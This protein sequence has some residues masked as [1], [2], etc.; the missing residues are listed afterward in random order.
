M[1]NKKWIAILCTSVLACGMT[2]H[3]APFDAAYY[4]QQNPDVVAVVGNDAAAL[5]A[6]YNAFGAAEG[7][8]G[9]A[10]DAG[11]KNSGATGI[12]AIFDAA[13]YAEHN[14]D[15]VALV[16]NDPMALYTHF[17]TVGINEGRFGNATFNAAAYKDANPDLAAVY[18]ND[19]LAYAN[20]Y[21]TVG[22]AEGRK[23]GIS[24]GSNGSGSSAKAN[25]PYARFHTSGS[26]SSTKHSKGDSSN[27]EEESSPE[28]SSGNNSG[29]N[30]ESSVDAFTGYKVNGISG[31]DELKVG[32]EKKYVFSVDVTGSIPEGFEVYRAIDDIEM[33]EDA[34]KVVEW[35]DDGGIILRVDKY[36]DKPIILTAIFNVRNIGSEGR[37][38]PNNRVLAHE[39]CTKTITIKNSSESE[40]VDVEKLK[41]EFNNTAEGAELLKAKNDLED[42]FLKAQDAYDDAHNAVIE[43]E[44]EVASLEEERDKAQE[45][46]NNERFDELD[47]ECFNATNEL[48]ELR[49]K[50]A[51]L[52]NKMKDA[53]DAWYDANDAYYDAFEEF[54]NN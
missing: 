46:G 13:Y 32:D 16:G 44:K 52:E 35:S 54:K 11:A 1:R 8:V 41:E 40:T 5:E 2:V 3:A 39:E 9:N 51:D 53:E 19:L 38:D 10:Q 45:E 50:Q 34:V 12:A 31:P 42:A 25:D 26:S 28:S 30:S 23:T 49:D 18:G 33:D 37:D 22:Q 15:V 17:I 21:M 6:H 29:N 27:E 36:T 24:S 48:L 7:R 43:K 20:H 47:E 4:A 14:L